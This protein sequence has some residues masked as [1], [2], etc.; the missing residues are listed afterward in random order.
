MDIQ[1]QKIKLVDDGRP[2]VRVMFLAE[3]DGDLHIWFQAPGNGLDA[4]SSTPARRRRLRIGPLAVEILN[5][6]VELA[7]G[8]RA[9]QVCLCVYIG[10][11]CFG[12]MHAKGA[13]VR[14]QQL[15]TVYQ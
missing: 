5:P 8:C 9:K 1:N 3:P 14:T 15:H 12:T 4:G 10:A 11:E 13:Q 7:N 2:R 6:T